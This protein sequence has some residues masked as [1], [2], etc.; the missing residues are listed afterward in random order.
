[1]VRGVSQQELFSHIR[2]KDHKNKNLYQ[3]DKIIADNLFS[4]DNN[5]FVPWC[6]QQCVDCNHDVCFHS[7]PTTT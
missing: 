4:L 1:M 6:C 2:T 7:Q 3:V 5:Y